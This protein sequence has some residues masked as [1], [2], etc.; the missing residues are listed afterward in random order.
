MALR[1]ITASHREVRRDFHGAGPV[2]S[3]QG[4]CRRSVPEASPMAADTNRAVDNRRRW[5]PTRAD[6]RRARLA[7]GERRDSTDAALRP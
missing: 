5:S 4:R 1:T 7:N 2:G 6:G 3:C